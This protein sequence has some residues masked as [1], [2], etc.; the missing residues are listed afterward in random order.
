M[1][2]LTINGYIITVL[3]LELKHGIT[4]ILDKL[5]ESLNWI[6]LF[7]SCSA[8]AWKYVASTNFYLILH[9]PD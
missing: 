5:T 7:N 1:V 4:E 9:C 6:L 2:T 3:V 8:G